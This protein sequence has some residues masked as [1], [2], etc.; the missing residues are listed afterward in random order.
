MLTVFA[1]VLSKDCSSVAMTSK[2]LR[3]KRQAAVQ[4]KGSIDRL[5]CIC[6]KAMFPMLLCGKKKLNRLTR[7][8]RVRR[9]D[10]FIDILS[11][12]TKRK[13]SIK[14]DRG[15]LISLILGLI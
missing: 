11:P 15:F 4:K 6:L 1:F 3:G 12:V 7:R 2:R 13:A 5:Y 8:T 14:N 10:C 9:N